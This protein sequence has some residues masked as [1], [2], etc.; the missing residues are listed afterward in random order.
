MLTFVGGKWVEIDMPNYL[1]PTWS[2]VD[3]AHF[4]AAFVKARGLGLSNPQSLAEGLVT[5]LR[6]PDTSYD[7][8]FMKK[9]LD[10]RDTI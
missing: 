7:S 4:A 10:L 5:L 9:L 3:R 2:A 8:V 1:D 6:Y